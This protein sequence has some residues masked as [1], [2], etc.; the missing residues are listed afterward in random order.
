MEYEISP[1]E[2][3]RLRREKNWTQHELATYAGLS[4]QGVVS[5]VE[6]G[7]RPG[8]QTE[9]RLREALGLLRDDGERV[10]QTVTVNK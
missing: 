9:H 3:R 1:D 5:Q 8:P 4:S 10:S 7:L 6:N 2:W